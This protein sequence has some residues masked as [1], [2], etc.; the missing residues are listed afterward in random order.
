M[1]LCNIAFANECD[2]FYAVGSNHA[3][4]IA[5]TDEASG[6]PQGVAFELFSAISS[7]LK[8]PVQYLAG[9]AWSRAN[10]WLD[11]GEVDVLLGVY[12]TPEREQKWLLSAPFL[13][14]GSGIF[15]LSNQISSVK[16]LQDLQ[17]L[18]GGA[19]NSSSY[20][21]LIDKHKEQ[22]ALFYTTSERELF[23]MLLADRLDYV[24]AA[25]WDAHHV[26]TDMN[27]LQE[28]SVVPELGDM[29]TLH[30][31]FSRK[32]ACGKYIEQVNEL[33]NQYRAS[34]K[35]DAWLNTFQ[36]NNVSSH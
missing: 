31:A 34:G 24:V 27:A 36:R 32:T 14:E 19:I 1:S 30:I 22:L 12:S 26:L 3:A 28:V 25:Q 33:I 13:E 8:V 29:N 10:A 21:E 17:G 9:V 15:M 18:R 20:G 7:E 2:N 23:R 6:Q 4:P 11:V 16:S 5:Y 35:I